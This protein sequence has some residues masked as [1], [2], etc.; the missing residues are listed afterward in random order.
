M[1]ESAT[2]SK[3]L[4]GALFGI[5]GGILLLF[6]GTLIYGLVMEVQDG[7]Y[8]CLWVIGGVVALMLI[9]G[10]LGWRFL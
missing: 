7:D 4:N 5:A 6:I 9:G 8:G 1:I 3:V 2:F 10:Y